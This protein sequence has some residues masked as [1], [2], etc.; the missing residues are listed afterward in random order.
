MRS[1]G[2]LL[3][4]FSI[5]HKSKMEKLRMYFYNFKNH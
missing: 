3:L 4:V 5:R 2:L 1:H